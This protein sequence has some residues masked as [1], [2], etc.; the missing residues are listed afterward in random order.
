[1]SEC[2]F[3]MLFYYEKEAMDTH[4]IELLHANDI[5]YKFDF[6]TLIRKYNIKIIE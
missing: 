3:Q 5:I 1:M 4:I 2:N 6:I